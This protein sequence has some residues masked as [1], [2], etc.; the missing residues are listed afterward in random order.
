L[1]G[2]GRSDKSEKV[3]NHDCK[4]FSAT[5]VEFVTKIRYEHLS[6]EDKNKDEMKSQLHKVLHTIGTTETMESTEGATAS[7]HV[8]MKGN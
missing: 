2:W 7:N 3:N 5:N 8:K 1:W 6:E 4:V